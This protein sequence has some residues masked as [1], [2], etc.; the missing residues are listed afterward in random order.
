MD[1]SG[2]I[3]LGIV[4][5][6]VVLLVGAV[7]YREFERQRDIREVQEVMQGI[8]SYAAQSLEQDQRA[9]RQQQALRA[10]QQAVERARYELADD[11]QCVGGYVVQVRGTVYTQLG[12][13]GSPV[14]CTGRVADRPLR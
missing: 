9:A 13:V 5:A 6:A 10:A 3:A 4:G 1:G 2:K 12:S 8:T 14:R 7:A 11:M